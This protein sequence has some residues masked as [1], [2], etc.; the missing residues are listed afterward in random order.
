MFLRFVVGEPYRRCPSSR[1]RKRPGNPTD[2]AEV[3]LYIDGA[4][5]HASFILRRVLLICRSSILTL[6][7]VLLSDALCA[8]AIP[9]RFSAILSPRE[10]RQQRGDSKSCGEVVFVVKNL[11]VQGQRVRT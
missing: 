2:T 10:H 5:F 11:Y 4:F 7:P 8:N 3:E 6:S 9:A 1:G